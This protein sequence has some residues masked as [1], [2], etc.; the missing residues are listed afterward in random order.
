MKIYKDNKENVIISLTKEENETLVEALKTA[1]EELDLVKKGEAA[2][3][4]DR[5]YAEKALNGLS[6]VHDVYMPNNTIADIAKRYAKPAIYKC[7][8]KEYDELNKMPYPMWAAFLDELAHY[9][10]TCTYCKV[11][12]TFTIG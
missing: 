1:I 2:T 4:T 9:S 8:S 11:Y 7:G 12:D 5:E 6:V 10:V 3:A